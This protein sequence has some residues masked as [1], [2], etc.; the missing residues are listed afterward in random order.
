MLMVVGDTKEAKH[1]FLIY[2]YIENDN[3]GFV[4]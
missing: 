2:V 3:L 1:Q 4:Y